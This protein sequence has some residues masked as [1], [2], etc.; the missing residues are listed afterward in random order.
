MP[1][2][3]GGG[4]TSQIACR[5]QWR[6][7]R[8][9][10]RSALAVVSPLESIWTS[11]LSPEDGAAY[12]AFVVGA[13]GRHFSQ[14]RDWV[15]VAAAT[16]P[17]RPVFF[18]ARRDGRVVGAALVLRSRIVLPLPLAKIER[19]P[20][21]DDPDDLPDVLTALVQQAHRHGVLRLSVMPYWSEDDKRTVERV[22][23]SR[24]FSDVQTYTGSHV[25]ALRLDLSGLP[26]AD[27]FAGGDFTKLRKEL[28]RAERAGAA[29]RRGTSTDVDAFREMMS[30]RLR[31]ENKHGP[32]LEYFEALKRYF[33]TDKAA[34]FVGEYQ[35]EPVSVI[36]ATR[37]GPLGIYV[38]GASDDRDLTFSKMIQPMAQAVLWAKDQGC[39]AFDFGGMP[40][41]GDTDPKRNSIALFKR[42][43]SRTEIALG[44]EHARWF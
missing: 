19:G 34:I 14:T 41:I 43:F 5:P 9:I 18:L 31:S 36:L 40:M 21:C 8:L 30:K 35:A 27:P 44:H 4:L 23:Q 33:S 3:A 2:G 24:G 11:Q 28:R 38:A 39:A 29:A 22:L 16:R 26:A 25:R 15:E 20:V 13:R 1:G 7:S 37:H 42:S 17:C 12:D 32:G 10:P 6:R